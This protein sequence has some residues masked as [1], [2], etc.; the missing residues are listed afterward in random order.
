[1]TVRPG[2]RGRFY[3]DFAA[4][5][6]YRCRQGRTITQFDNIS[7]SLLTNNSNQLHFNDDYARRTEWGRCLVN[8]LLTLAVV[9]GLSTADVSEN[10]FALGWGTIELPH[11]VFAGDTLYSE[12]QVLDKRD[13]KSRPSQGIVEIETRGCNQ[14]GVLVIRFQRAVMVWKKEHAPVADLFPAP[15]HGEPERVIRRGGGAAGDQDERRR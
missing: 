1:M 14:D 10:G 12:S 2:W 8:S 4:G 9:T 11:P 6:V 3:E 13:S 7:F 15:G 5:D